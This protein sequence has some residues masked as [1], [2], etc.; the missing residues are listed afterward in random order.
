MGK[1]NRACCVKTKQSLMARRNQLGEGV[2]ASVARTMVSAKKA[3]RA[4]VLPL[5][6]SSGMRTS[7]ACE[8]GGE[9]V[10]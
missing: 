5:M 4:C 8:G 7:F 1:R 10:R 2:K 6:S 3:K 9:G